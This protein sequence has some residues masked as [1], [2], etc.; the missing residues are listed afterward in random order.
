MV[1]VIERIQ[2]AEA[3]ERGEP[4]EDNHFSLSSS[5]ECTEV[6]YATERYSES[7]PRVGTKSDKG[8]DAPRKRRREFMEF[9]LRI[10][11]SNDS[12]SDEKSTSSRGVYLLAIHRQ[13][14]HHNNMLQR[15]LEH[16]TKVL[17]YA[18]HLAMGDGNDQASGPF[19][20]PE[21]LLIVI[22]ER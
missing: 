13:I 21:L 1:L 9:A 2:R 7:Q 20:P 6:E 17:R 15:R 8:E 3:C 18:E 14:D 22:G 16:S 19:H 11:V 5:A 10:Q 12:S 4:V